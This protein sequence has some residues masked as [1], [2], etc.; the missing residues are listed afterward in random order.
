MTLSSQYS[1]QQLQHY[2][3]STYSFYFVGV[4]INTIWCDSIWFSHASDATVLVYPV[5]R[6]KKNKKFC[7]STTII[8][9][10]QH[11]IVGHMNTQKKKTIS[12]ENTT[13][14]NSRIHKIFDNEF[15]NRVFDKTIWFRRIRTVNENDQ[16][17]SYCRT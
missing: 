11:Q 7:N 12:W 16:H 14:V 3:M 13:N 15:I 2:Q 1:S 6:I 9:W 8:N 10:P 4:H 5:S 17:W